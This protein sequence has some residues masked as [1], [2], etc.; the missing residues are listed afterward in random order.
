[1]KERRSE[2]GN[3]NQR[4]PFAVPST[5]VPSRSVVV[6]SG[7]LW[8]LDLFDVELKFQKYKNCTMVLSFF[9]IFCCKWLIWDLEDNLDS[10]RS[11]GT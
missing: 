3:A 8:S 2:Q 1:M 5:H 4:A 9:L 10:S 11:V 6:Y 7:A